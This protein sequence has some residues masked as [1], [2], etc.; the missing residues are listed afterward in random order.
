MSTTTKDEVETNN[1]RRKRN[2]G[3]WMY[4]GT[5]L[6]LLAP[7]LI[8]RDIGLP[9]F[10]QST[11]SIGDTIGGITAPIVGIMGAVLVYYALLAQIEANKQIN[12]QFQE[13]QKTTIQQN[14]EQTF[15]SLLNIHHEIVNNIRISSNSLKLKLEPDGSKLRNLA[16]DDLNSVKS[17]IHNI[18][19]T[20]N[21]KYLNAE[22][23]KNPV[24]HKSREFFK[25]TVEIME[26]LITTLD[27][28]NPRCA[29]F[30]K[31]Y[32]FQGEKSKHADVEIVSFFHSAYKTMFKKLDSDLGHYYR[33]LYRIVKMISEQTFGETDEKVIYDKQ[34]VYTSIVRSQLS[35][36]EIKWLFYNGLFKYGEK[37]KPLIEEFTLL[38]ILSRNDS[39]SPIEKDSEP[40]K[41]LKPLYRDIAF[42]KVVWNETTD[43]NTSKKTYSRKP[44]HEKDEALIKE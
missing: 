44:G 20:F 15:F 26:D 12:D 35:D 28:I 38:K 6:V 34:Y 8:S 32:E 21:D 10:T 19:K 37:F 33:N 24:E 17:D 2:A 16:D 22:S 29:E 41:K 3:W 4:G 25:Y 11:G 5:S 18:A 42:E 40:I 43:P 9:P 27:S 30:V 1:K 13:Q 39:D 23:T 31:D 14:F 36:Y 7:F